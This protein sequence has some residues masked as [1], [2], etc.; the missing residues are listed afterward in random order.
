[1][2]DVVNQAAHLAHKAGRGYNDPI[3]VGAE[4]FYNLNDDDSKLLTQRWDGEIKSWVHT[5][6]VVS[7]D[8]NTWIDTNF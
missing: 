4:F 3:W 7:T 6:N 2:G 5:G 1:M 8:M